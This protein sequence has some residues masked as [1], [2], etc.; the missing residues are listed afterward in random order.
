MTMMT[1]EVGADLARLAHEHKWDELRDALVRMHP[2]DVADVIIALPSEDEG[3]VFRLLTHEQA[4]RVLSDLPRDHQEGLIR[5]LSLDQLRG[6]L[7]DIAPDDRT[8]LF[9]EMPAEVTRRL[10]E[11][12]GPEELKASR[13]LLGYPPGTAGRYMTPNYASIRPQMT[14]RQ[15]LEHIRGAPARARRPSASSTWS[16]STARSSR[17][18]AS[19]H[20]SSPIRRPVSRRSKTRRSYA[21]WRRAHARR[22]C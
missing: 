10:L 7:D 22:C 19:V 21:S 18:C 6:L 11:S 3:I 16:T 14:A 17:T 15:V 9:D 12:L 5:S 2:A 4:G 20:S 8:R 13:N 1:A